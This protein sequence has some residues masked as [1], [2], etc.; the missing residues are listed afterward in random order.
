M[1]HVFVDIFTG[2]FF[3]IIIVVIIIEPIL[4]S[5]RI[6]TLTVPLNDTNMEM[7]NIL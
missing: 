2:F 3:F 4:Y 5:I 1:F 7:R 6:L